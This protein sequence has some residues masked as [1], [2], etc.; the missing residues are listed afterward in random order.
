MKV[1]FQDGLLFVT[2][3]VTYQGQTAELT[4]VLLDTGS[5]GTVLSAT[6]F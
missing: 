2:L 6:V 4:D 3:S 1:R 5:A